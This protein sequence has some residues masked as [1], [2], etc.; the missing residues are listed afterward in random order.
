MPHNLSGNFLPQ[1]FTSILS[2]RFVYIAYHSGQAS[3][4]FSFFLYR[5]TTQGIIRF[6]KM[7][8][9]NVNCNN[10]RLGILFLQAHSCLNY[11]SCTLIN[12]HG[13]IWHDSFTLLYWLR[14]VRVCPS[15]E[16]SNM[17]DGSAAGCQEW[18]AR[19]ISIKVKIHSKTHF[20]SPI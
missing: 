9:F 20:I 5:F 18:T 15:Q 13:N 14:P 4:F 10:G 3:Y 17:E 7:F 1:H 12:H 19:L 6:R 8:S 2:R 11:Y 16:M